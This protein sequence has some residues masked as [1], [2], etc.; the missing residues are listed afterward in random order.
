[1]SINWK[2]EP[3][4]NAVA[5]SP[6][7]Y[8][9]ITRMTERICLTNSDL[10]LGRRAPDSS[11]AHV[12]DRKSYDWC[13]RLCSG[14][15]VL[16]RDHTLIQSSTD[17]DLINVPGYLDALKSSSRALCNDMFLYYRVR[18]MCETI[19]NLSNWNFSSKFCKQFIYEADGMQ[20]YIK[21]KSEKKSFIF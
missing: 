3:R 13:D 18:R 15:L 9:V 7:R 5:G 14:P 19:P 20:T 21:V 4:A 2:G 8:D 1:M 16:S 10:F 17:R 12:T 6:S 11:L